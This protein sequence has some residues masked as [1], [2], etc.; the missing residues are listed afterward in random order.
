MEMTTGEGVVRVGQFIIV[1]E[2]IQ[3]FVDNVKFV[4]GEI[5]DLSGSGGGG[6]KEIEEIEEMQDE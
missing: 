3:S 6:I 2:V 5:A 1:Q 4:E